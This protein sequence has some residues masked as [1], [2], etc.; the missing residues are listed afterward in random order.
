MCWLTNKLTLLKKHSDTKVT[1]RLRASVLA[2]FIGLLLALT[3]LAAYPPGTVTAQADYQEVRLQVRTITGAPAANVAVNLVRVFDEAPMGARTTDPSGQAV[4]FVQAGLEYVFILSDD[5]Q[6]DPNTRNQLGDMGLGGFGIIAGRANNPNPPLPVTFALVLADETAVTSG[7]YAFMDANP[8]GNPE[9]IIM[10]E[11]H[12]ADHTSE[13]AV[14]DETVE[15]FIIQLPTPEPESLDL[16]D[17]GNP[18]TEQFRWGWWLLAV[19]LL[20]LAVGIWLYP[21]LKQLWQG[22]SNA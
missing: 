5:I 20:L 15:E 4:W 11:D 14:P 7:S 13:T 16:A 19:L 18:V 6:L 3:A 17:D 9:P 1:P 22:T 2:I 21:T 8:T 12:P 10:P